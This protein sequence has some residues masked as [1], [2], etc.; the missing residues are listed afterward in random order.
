M[1][2]VTLSVATIVT[3]TLSYVLG[4]LASTGLVKTAC[5]CGIVLNGIVACWIVYFQL[6]KWPQ[7]D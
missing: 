3:S 5:I 7:N 4:A 1:K 6:I 2:P